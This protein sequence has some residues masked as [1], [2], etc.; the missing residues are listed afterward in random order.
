MILTIISAVLITTSLWSSYKDFK[1][2]KSL[3]KNVYFKNPVDYL[4]AILIAFLVFT[5][6]SFAYSFKLPGFL[7]WSWLELLSSDGQSSGNLILKPFTSGVLSYILVFWFVMSLA[8]PYLAKGEEKAF[9]SSVFS[10]KKRIIESFKFGFIHMIVGVPVIAGF[11]LSIVGYIFS[12]WY[13]K[14]YTKAFKE[15][16]A[17]LADEMGIDRSTSLHAKY[18]FVL[19]TFVALMCLLLIVFGK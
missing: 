14:G 10:Q 7:T 1:K 11:V 9:R 3:L 19:I 6:L 16:K 15:G 4:F 8:L 17:E 12:I 2:D 18:N 5:S 13:I